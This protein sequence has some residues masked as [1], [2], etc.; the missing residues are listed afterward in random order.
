MAEELN[1][2]PWQQRQWELLQ[3]QREQGKLPHAVM[4]LGR[5][6]LGLN[7]FARL[8]A[9]SMFCHAPRNDFLPCG[10]CAACRQ[11]DQGVYPDYTEVSLLDD[12]RSILV[13]QI[14]D[15][16]EFL[17]LTHGGHS[18]K[19]VV[20]SPAEAMNINAA[21]SLL[22]TLEEPPGEVLIIL[23]AHSVTTLPATVKSRC[24]FVHFASPE[25]N[26]AASWLAGQS[27]ERIEERLLLAG[28]APCRALSLSDE[29]LEQYR[30]AA[31]HF[32][33]VLTGKVAVTALRPGKADADIRDYVEW[34]HSLVRDLLRAQ[35]A[36][37]DTRFENRFYIDE[38]RRLAT[39]VDS[40]VL[41][42]AHE[43]IAQIWG[44]LDHPLNADLLVD[45]LLLTWN[46]LK[47]L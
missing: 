10:Q 34:A 41:H 4:L 5:Q 46:S 12:K 47:H 11:F 14:R 22:K 39:S 30:R 15:L 26:V 40:S 36:S 23:V 35:S 38:L 9:R 29:Y 17:S 16:T 33:G 44:A 20:L 7:H 1:P 45:E 31:D 19:S 24:Q 32:L 18:L 8:L 2:Y 43:R 28:G 25:W 42:R 21:N 37:P 27:A 6:G 13:D 3:H